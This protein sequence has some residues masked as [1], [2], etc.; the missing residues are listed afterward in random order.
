[1]TSS[2]EREIRDAVAA[3][4]RELVPSARIVHELNVCGTGSNRID[5]A[6]VA[7]ELIVAVEIKS[8]KDKLDR[9]A[10]Q[11]PAFNACCHHVV[12][13]AHEKHF[14]AHPEINAHIRDDLPRELTLNHPLFVKQ[15]FWGHKVWR[16]PRPEKGEFGREPSWM[17]ST[18]WD[19]VR[20]RRAD[21]PRAAAMLDMLWAE[22]LR[23]ECARHRLD[24]GSRRTRPDMI[25][26]MVWMMT[27]R[28]ICQAVCR[29]IRAR[30]FAEADPAI[31][32]ERA[33]IARQEALA[34]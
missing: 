12:V 25:A 26:D 19:R 9:L 21:Q 3:R 7:P 1:M 34:L 8:R 2:D 16:Y 13:A 22:E 6:A 18:H 23:Y 27:G 4:L 5:V 10:E 20:G 24:S 11:W 17:F 28:E 14:V 30:V 33:Q 15:R 29:Q 31:A 32:I